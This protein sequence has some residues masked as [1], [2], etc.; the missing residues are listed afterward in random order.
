[1][2]RSFLFLLLGPARKKRAGK[3]AVAVTTHEIIPPKLGA[4]AHP[5]RKPAQHLLLHLNTTHPHI[6][7]ETPPHKT[8]IREKTVTTHRPIHLE[9]THTL[10]HARAHFFRRHTHAWE[11]PHWYLRRCSRM[12]KGTSSCEG[13]RGGGGGGGRLHVGERDGDA[14]GGGKGAWGWIWERVSRFRNWGG[15][16][17]E[18]EKRQGR[19][20]GIE[21]WEEAQR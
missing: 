15:G 6:P 4:R 1:M 13:E 11:Q 5:A 18:R 19:E 8:Q 14:G 16:G 3:K 10:M 2:H 20:A 7:Q 21:S 17:E 12:R 9:H